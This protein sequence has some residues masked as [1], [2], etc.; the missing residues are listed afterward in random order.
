MPTPADAE[1]ITQLGTFALFVFLTMF[2]GIALWRR[3]IV[4]GY[5]YTEEKTARMTAETQAT[6]NADALDS[7]NTLMAEQALVMKAQ[8]EQIAAQSREL[9]GL[10]RD[11][12]ALRDDLGRR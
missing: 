8:V 3:W 9:A 12:K 7:N 5:F 2:A 10:R 11:L 6:R 1:A 4:L